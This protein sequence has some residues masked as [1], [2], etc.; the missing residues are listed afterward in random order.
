[1][2]R[3]S[4]GVAS[5]RNLQSAQGEL[6]TS[7][8][9]EEEDVLPRLH[10]GR[11]VPPEPVDDDDEVPENRESDDED[12]FEVD[13]SNEDV[14]VH[15]R[16]NH[17]LRGSRQTGS[18]ISKGFAGGSV[19]R[20]DPVRKRLLV[21]SA[22]GNPR[23]Q[24]L[25]KSDSVTEPP[26]K[27][28]RD[29]IDGDNSGHRSTGRSGGI[30]EAQVRSTPSSSQNI[31][32]SEPSV[33]RSFST[34]G[35]S[36]QGA[37]CHVGV[38]RAG[39]VGGF[40]GRAGPTAGVTA[41]AGGTP[42]NSNTGIPRMTLTPD[43]ESVRETPSRD[44]SSLELEAKKTINAL[45]L[46]LASE[47]QNNKRLQT[48]LD[49]AHDN[50]KEL[51]QKVVEQ[52]NKILELEYRNQTQNTKSKGRAVMS[53][54]A[55]REEGQLPQQL[56]MVKPYFLDSQVLSV[57][58][59][60]IV[61]GTC[62]DHDDKVRVSWM[63]GV[64]ALKL[65]SADLESADFNGRP[66]IQLSSP[67]DHVSP[68]DGGG[69][70]GS[71]GGPMS[72]LEVVIRSPMYSLQNCPC[73]DEI[74]HQ[75]M[76]AYLESNGYGRFPANF[77]GDVGLDTAVTK[78]TEHL[79]ANFHRKIQNEFATKR[80]RG[81]ELFFSQIGAGDMSRSGNSF[82]R[83]HRLQLVASFW[84]RVYGRGFPN[85]AGDFVSALSGSLSTGAITGDHLSRYRYMSWEDISERTIQEPA[86]GFEDV[87]M[88]SELQ[89]TDELFRNNAAR[90]LCRSFRGADGG[91]GASIV[92]IARADAAVGSAAFVAKLKNAMCDIAF[93]KIAEIPDIDDAHREKARLKMLSSMGGGRWPLF[94]TS[95]CSSFVKTS[96]EHILRELYMGMHRSHNELL[97]KIM[98]AE[99]KWDIRHDTR[100][101]EESGGLTR[102]VG[103]GSSG[104][105][106]LLIDMNFFKDFVCPWYG[107][108][109]DVVIG[110]AAEG[111]SLFK[112]IADDPQLVSFADIAAAFRL[113]GSY[114]NAD[115]EQPVS[116]VVTSDECQ[117]DDCDTLG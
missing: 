42:P 28:V 85:A 52:E 98:D 65:G 41:S 23:S 107:S 110:H 115:G 20:D 95:V 46:E 64:N 72:P 40:L 54:K 87:R 111:D 82:Q 15:S 70:S 36:P 1:M 88:Q 22:D 19:R 47:A 93:K 109:F 112:C 43:L 26:Q 13:D 30:Q 10:L 102:I 62:F 61:K 104:G 101:R 16:D 33:F 4:A 56:R 34:S 38:S 80:S 58:V 94:Q 114:E 17:S 117:E 59:Q 99:G 86:I 8:V 39:Y 49:L 89:K 71:K 9:D 78:L 7:R 106:F 51:R 83:K 67:I 90:I 12:D 63:E 79:S 18:F 96:M 25:N 81:V 45:K 116:V 105:H 113:K 55:A 91:D 11:S 68:V 37:T 66:F 103:A 27:R 57:T 92:A 14:Q 75:C 53:K 48:S 60:N 32:G 3:G 97:Y 50:L 84:D 21:D 24:A 77:L 76:T 6:V 74:L 29:S 31:L 73:V 5:A 35:S 69:A 2:V 44:L 108:T 100:K